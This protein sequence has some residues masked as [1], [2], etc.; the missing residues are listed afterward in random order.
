M[1]LDFQEYHIIPVSNKPFDDAL[2]LGAELYHRVKDLLI[3]R[4]AGHALAMKVGLLRSVYQHGSSRD[5]K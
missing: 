1:N 5:S 3:H 4:G 2:R